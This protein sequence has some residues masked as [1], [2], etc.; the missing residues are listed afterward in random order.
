[1]NPA[2]PSLKETLMGL[3]KAQLVALHR[4]AKDPHK[5]LRPFF[6]DPRNMIALRR[7]MEDKHD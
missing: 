5:G 7:A 4:I 1:M 2:R 6:V 3:S